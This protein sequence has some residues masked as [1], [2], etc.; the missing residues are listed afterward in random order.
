MQGSSAG[1][2]HRSRDG[3]LR[4]GD[5]SRTPSTSKARPVSGRRSPF[6]VPFVSASAPTLPFGLVKVHKKKHRWWTNL[7][8]RTLSATADSG[9]SYFKAVLV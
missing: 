9:L 1:A 4:V 5:N 2:S 7:T 6:V 8:A 3:K